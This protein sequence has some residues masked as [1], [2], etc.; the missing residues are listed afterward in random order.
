M[1]NKEN[2]MVSREV[3]FIKSNG[4]EAKKI[5]EKIFL[6]NRISYFVEWEDRNI[7]SR[8]I[9]GKDK[10]A[11]VIRINEADVERAKELV[12]GVEGIKIR[13]PKN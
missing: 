4:L 5:V 6:E 8:I 13:K 1:V 2:G 3:A 7:F 11:F 10:N 12:Q 9:G